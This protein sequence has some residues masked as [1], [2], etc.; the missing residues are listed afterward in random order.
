VVDMIPLVLTVI[1]VPSEGRA[2]SLHGVATNEPLFLT[3]VEA[4]HLETTAMIEPTNVPC[5][6]ALLTMASPRTENA[7][8]SQQA[9]PQQA[10]VV[11]GMN[12]QHLGDSRVRC[13]HP[14]GLHRIKLR[15]P[16]MADSTSLQN[17]SLP[18]PEVRETL[19][20][21]P[22]RPLIIFLQVLQQIAVTPPVVSRS[23]NH[24]HLHQRRSLQHQPL[25]NQTEPPAGSIQVVCNNGTHLPF[26]PTLATLQVALVVQFG[27]PRALHHLPALVGHQLDPRLARELRAGLL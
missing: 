14:A 24:I 12:L 17:R 20:L 4:N 1:I 13:S 8:T 25:R 5:M 11:D 21:R 7:A 23:S 16:T 15:I 22:P 19:F 6:T 3:K 26:R 10:L 2:L 9:Q 18:V 27:R